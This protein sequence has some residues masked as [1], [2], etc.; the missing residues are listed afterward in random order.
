MYLYAHKVYSFFDTNLNKQN[1]RRSDRLRQSNQTSEFVFLVAR[2][3]VI[4]HLTVDNKHLFR[5]FLRVI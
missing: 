2:Q 4:I 3:V 5:Q 1:Q